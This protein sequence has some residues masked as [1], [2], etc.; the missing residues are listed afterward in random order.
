MRPDFE[1][2]LAQ[3]AAIG[4]KEVEPHDYFGRTPQEVRTLFDRLGLTSPSAH[5]GLARFRDDLPGLLDAST[6]IGHRYIVVPALDGSLRNP[7]GF[8]SV[9]ADLNRW[10]AM[11]RD[12]GI[13]VGY[14]N[15][16]FEFA[17]IPGGGTGFEILLGETD[18]ALVDFELDI[19]WAVKGG[20]NPLDLFARYPGRFPLWHVKDMSDRAGAQRMAD[21]GAGEIDFRGIFAAREQA[22]LRHFFVERD[23]PTDSLASIRTSY[24][25]LRRLLS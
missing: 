19:Y 1:G 23:D 25:N 20:H 16:D 11:A 4:Y 6:V 5:V 7:A 8:R 21:V 17:A 9:A 22:G 12:R 14:H 13:R 15:H 18:P 24:T 3:I 10:G 2:T